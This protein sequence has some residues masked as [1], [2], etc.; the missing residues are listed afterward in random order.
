MVKI[1]L[2]MGLELAYYLYNSLVPPSAWI[3][4]YW[5]AF[6]ISAICFLVAASGS[7]SNFFLYFSPKYD[8]IP[9]VHQ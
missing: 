3:P 5:Y 1:K 4:S 2:K 6:G 7:T 9:A 8:I